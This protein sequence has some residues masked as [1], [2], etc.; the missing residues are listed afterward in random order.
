MP[1]IS[2]ALSNFNAGELSPLLDGRF[3]LAKYSTG[4]S[5]MEHFQPTVQGAARFSP[6]TRYV[7]SCL[8]PDER[9]WLARFEFSDE[10][11]FVLEFSNN[12]LGFFQDRARLVVD[13]EADPIVNYVI[14]TPY[15]SASMLNVDGSW[16]LSLVQTGDVIYIAGAGYK[17]QKLSRISNL[18]WTLEDLVIE[19]GPFLEMNL[20]EDIVMT[21]T[22]CTIN[23]QGACVITSN[24]GVFTSGHVGALIRIERKDAQYLEPW[25]PTTAD[26]NI[27]TQVISDGK[28]YKCTDNYGTSVSGTVQPT[29]TRGKAND[30]TSQVNT[31]RVKEWLYINSGYGIARITS[32]ISATQVNAQVIKDFDFP[33]ELTL[34]APIPFVPNPPYGAPSS[35]WQFGAWSDDEDA[36]WPR[37][38]SLWRDRLVW[39]GLRDVWLSKSGEYEKMA[40][41][42]FG[43]QLPESGVNIRIQSQDNNAIRW[44]ATT[45]AVLVG[46]AAA[47]FAITEAATATPF[48]PAN[49]KSVRK[50]AF[51]G[52]G[53]KPV[54]AGMGTF[55]VE[56]TGRRVR[57]I[58]F[59]QESTAYS[60]KDVTI[61]AEHITASGIIQMEHQNFP[62][63]VLWAVRADG[64]LLGFTYEPDQDVYAWHQRPFSGLVE[65]VTTIPS[66]DGSRDDV[67]LSV[68]RVIDNAT[69][70][71]VERIEEFLGI[72]APIEDARHLECGLVYD[73]VP[74]STFY[75]TWLEGVTVAV[76]AD[77]AVIPSQT[78]TGG[79]ITLTKQYSMVYLGIPYTGRLRTMR[80]EGGSAE[81]TSQGKTKRLAKVVCRLNRSL[82]GRVG[83]SFDD[84][85]NILYRTPQDLMNVSPPLFSGDK[86][87]ALTS[88]FETDGYLCLEQNQPLPLDLLA[89]YPQFTTSD[90]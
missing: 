42:D 40:L 84:L 67:W 72:D 27:G 7:D 51:G 50:S 19:D 63:S 9:S 39:A 24:P 90:R 31:S 1:R 48:G 8:D 54:T 21:V 41:D 59:D 58:Q 78:V 82:G 79:E 81:G 56:K 88:G 14:A 6:G 32:L 15:T 30:T 85:Q 71:Y 77:G 23:P 44:L 83:N 5:T 46:T 74:A 37:F 26:Y 49:V 70:R 34:L 89:F 55:F 35:R 10:Q 43:E 13:P 75:P 22:G 66:P 25:V 16:A 69:V 3:D 87:L 29:H 52:S 4:C 76:M 36:E 45:N 28:T 68:L 64:V 47:E 57:E 11:A 86:I 60:A 20:D 61:L 53:V 33:A 2:P 17:P 80:L 18:D 62:E 65:S 73:S 38:V 12:Q